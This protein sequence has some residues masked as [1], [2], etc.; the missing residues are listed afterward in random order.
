MKQFL[1]EAMQKLL[2]SVKL[3]ILTEFLLKNKFLRT[4]SRG[5]VV[6]I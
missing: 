1:V 5:R 2:I 4:F 6:A 3:L